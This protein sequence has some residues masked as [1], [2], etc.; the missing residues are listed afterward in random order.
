M[1]D[2]WDIV[3]KHVGEAMKEATAADIPSDVVGRAFLACSVEIFKLTRSD[4]DIAAELNF[5]A[6]NVDESEPFGFMR[7]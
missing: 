1:S 2:V 3:R 5:K 6:D 4:A 7:P